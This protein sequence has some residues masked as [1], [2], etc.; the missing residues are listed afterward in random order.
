MNASCL[1]SVSLLALNKNVY[2]TF[3]THLLRSE[4]LYYIKFSSVIL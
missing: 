3:K 4:F 2:D 1:D